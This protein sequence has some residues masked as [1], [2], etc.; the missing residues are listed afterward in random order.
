MVSWLVLIGLFVG[1]LC[2][3]WT[4]RANNSVPVDIELIWIQVPRIELWSV[5]LIAMAAGAILSALFFGFA[6]LRQRLLSGRYRRAIKRL[7]T[8]LHE[9]RSLPLASHRSGKSGSIEE[10]EAEQVAAP[11][12]GAVAEQA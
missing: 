2:M 3:G 1:T 6:W 4:F 9:M 10:V 12:A 11:E 5:I 8:E 7:E